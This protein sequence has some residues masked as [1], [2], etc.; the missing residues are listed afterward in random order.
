MLRDIV[1]V[2]RYKHVYFID[3]VTV[4]SYWRVGN[5]HNK[6]VFVWKTDEK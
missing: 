3:I 1:G 5:T 2:V 4:L 6:K